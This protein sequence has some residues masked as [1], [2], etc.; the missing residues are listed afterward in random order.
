MIKLLM[1]M[2]RRPDMTF[3]QFKTY[4]ETNHRLIGIKYNKGAKR[5]TRRYLQKLE[6]PVYGPQPE[7]AYDVLTEI[8]FENQAA[9]DRG[10]AQITE[11]AA[12]KEIAEDSARLF[13][14]HSFQ[15]FV[16]K[17]EGVDDNL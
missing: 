11:P 3:E 1:L 10:L 17:D 16:V 12:A 7:P 8:W 4:Y 5:Y 13:D 14:G 15:M 6:N 9:L 2:K